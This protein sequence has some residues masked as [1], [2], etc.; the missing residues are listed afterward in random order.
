M[1]VLSGTPHLEKLLA[2]YSTNGGV[3]EHAVF[4]RGIL[5]PRDIEVHRHAAQE[6]LEA[7]A[8]R[9]KQEHERLIQQETARRRKSSP[10]KQLPTIPLR[11]EGDTIRLDLLV[12]REIGLPELLGRNF[13]ILCEAYVLP[14]SGVKEAFLNGYAE[15]FPLIE[16]LVPDASFDPEVLDFDRRGYAYAF[17]TAPDGLMLTDVELATLFF[18][19]AD[20]LFCA[21]H[22]P[23]TI[24]QWSTNSSNYFDAGHEWWGSFFW[25]VEPEG[26]DYIVSI[27]AS[28]TD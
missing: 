25:T 9:A 4:E 13:H 21:F 3:V 26:A 5:A 14:G 17:S 16:T 1:N 24:F 15:L 28:T 6:T 7:I 8:R 20:E 2:R 19:I 11:Y 10:W 27:T 22:C 23:L 18:A 12:G